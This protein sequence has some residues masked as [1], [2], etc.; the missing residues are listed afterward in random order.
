MAMAGCFGARNLVAIRA[1]RIEEDGSRIC[2]NVDGGAAMTGGINSVSA[3]LRIDA[4]QTD[5]QRDGD[6]N[7]CNTRT[8]NDVI[9]GVD[10]T[11]EICIFDWELIET[12]TGGTLAVNGGFTHGWEVALS[13]DAPPHTQFDA[14]ARTWDGAGQATSAHAYTRFTSYNTTWV[15][16]QITMNEGALTLPL[17][18]KGS[19]NSN[20]SIGLWNDIPTEFVGS[21]YGM[22]TTAAADLPDSPNA[23]GNDCGYVDVPA[24]TS[25]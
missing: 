9:T 19:E 25:S 24:C 21:F 23:D 15:P 14:W 1:G 2:P 5:V 22:W 4:G 7:V 8:S 20:I 3:S 13:S 16:G 11:A 6:G 10:L 18:G 12:L 17:T